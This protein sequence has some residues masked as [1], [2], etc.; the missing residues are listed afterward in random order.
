MTSTPQTTG[1][2]PTHC[3]GPRLAAAALAALLLAGCHHGGGGSAPPLGPDVTVSGTVTFD[4]VPT[5]NIG[6]VWQL[7]YANTRSAPARGITVQI[8]NGTNVVASTTTDD[9]GTYSIT[10]EYG[11]GGNLAPSTGYATLTI[12]KLDSYLC[13][14]AALAKGQPKFEASSSAL[15]ANPAAM[16]SLAFISGA[17]GAGRRPL[18]PSPRPYSAP[19]LFRK[20]SSPAGRPRNFS[21][22]PASSVESGKMM[23]ESSS[24][25]R[26]GFCTSGHGSSSPSFR[27]SVMTPCTPAAA[28]VSGEKR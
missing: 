11:G 23:L 9:T 7:D 2:R 21:T 15:T 18:G 17:A 5:A 19:M 26:S 8:M 27:G 10:A 1:T 16:E 25:Y 12:G 24:T 6:G 22:C 3:T 28:A 13:Y 14:K 4:L 20:A